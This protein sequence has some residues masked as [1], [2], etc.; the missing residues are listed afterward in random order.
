[1]LSRGYT[2]AEPD[3]AITQP[4][5]LFRL[6]S[7]SKMFTSAAIYELLQAHKVNAGDKVFPMLGLAPLPGQTPPPNLNDITVQNLIDHLGGWDATLAAFD[8][9]FAS[10]TIGTFFG[11]STFP[12]KRQIAQYMVG[13]PLQFTPG[14][15][16]NLKDAKGNPRNPYSNFG[17]VM[18]GLV[19]EHVSGKNFIDYVQQQTCAP[20]GISD[21]FLGRTLMSLKRSNEALAED[22]SLSLT[23]LDPTSTLLLPSAYGGFIVETMD[24]GGGL[25]ASTPSL[26]RF[27]HHY[28]AWGASLRAPGAA[29]TGSESGTRTRV[30]SR[31]NGFDYA[32]TFNTRY[33]LEGS[34]DAKGTEYIDHFGSDLEA[35]LDATMLAGASAGG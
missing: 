24:S 1:V 9:V 17:Y 25:I 11:L 12:S 8:P 18:L 3:Y 4:N 5:T 32:F 26:A 2:W 35:L 14:T 6:A 27:V 33:N 20:L 29:R 16:P 22:P 34:V 23:A 10:R 13:Q 31:P 7:V 15:N 19:V 21:V 30:G 28:A